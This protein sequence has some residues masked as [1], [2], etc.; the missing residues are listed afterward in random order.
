MIE[1]ASLM[2]LIAIPAGLGLLGFVEPCSLASTLLF[3]KYV[4]GRTG[5][6]KVLA[7]L[8]FAASRA[9]FIGGL[10]ALAALLGAAFLPIQH[11]L[12]VI[13]GA[14]VGTVGGLYLMGRQAVLFRL[15]A[16]LWPARA[17]WRGPVGVG[18][19]FGLNLP[20]CAAPILAVMIGTSAAASGGALIPS[21]GALFVFG[22]ALSAPLAAAMIWPSGR[23]MLER[24]AVL[25]ERLPT[26]T[27][28]VFL[29]LG[30]WSAASGLR[31]LFPGEIP[32]DQLIA[33]S[34][35]LFGIALPAFHVLLSRAAG[36]WSAA[37]GAGC[38]FG[39]RAGWL[40]VVTLLP[41]VGWLM[42][43]S[44]MRKRQNPIS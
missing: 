27:G 30:L 31:A 8:L 15:I 28:I 11:G 4:E 5:R 13:L 12:W 25:A 21:I 23:A 38:P 17:S 37:P 44:A 9:L 33:W 2:N 43:A 14:A 19:A 16:P 10:G 3:L 1:P 7:V 39:P 22:L 24:I 6:D 26:V 36:G 35:V 34:I 42:F 32:Q 18:F 29:L 20:A 41:F 40:I